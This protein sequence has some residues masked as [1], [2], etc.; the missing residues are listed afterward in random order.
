MPTRP[1][2]RVIALAT[3]LLTA[4]G[5]GSSA[6]SPPAGTGP[7]SPSPAS[8]RPSAASPGPSASATITPGGPLVSPTPGGS[9]H[10][11]PSPG[12]TITLHN[13]SNGGTFCVSIG[14]RVLVRLDSKPSRMWS[15]IRSDS[16]ALVP[17]GYGHLMLRVGE[18]GAY[19]AAVQPGI[20]HLSSARPLCASGPVHCGALMAFQVTVMVGGMQASPV[21]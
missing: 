6:A 1:V 20:A 5:C 9:C 14:Q 15:P 21:H 12:A 8:Q 11:V 7:A 2:L 3:V 19:F 13:S 10:S 18:T 17:L 4:A 16:R